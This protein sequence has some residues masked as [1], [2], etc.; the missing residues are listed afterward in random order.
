MHRNRSFQRLKP[1]AIGDLSKHVV[2]VRIRRS[3]TL[4]RSVCSRRAF[5]VQHRASIRQRIVTKYLEEL[6]VRDALVPAHDVV[7]QK[8]R[9]LIIFQ[10]VF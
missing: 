6:R 7:D 9:V 8:L 2:L 4:S 5:F 1:R 10:R 3:H